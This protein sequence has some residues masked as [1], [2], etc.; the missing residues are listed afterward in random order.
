MSTVTMT[1]PSTPPSLEDHLTRQLCTICQA[2]VLWVPIRGTL[3]LVDLYEWE[4]RSQ[5]ESCRHTRRAHPGRPVSCG[6]CHNTG[7]VGADRPKGRMVAM[8]MAWS[9][10]LHIRIIGPRT[11]RRRG[12][13]LYKFHQ[14][15]QPAAAQHQAAA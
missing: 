2:P 14:C 15:L 7:Y 1:R 10:E 4:P 13:A 9:D 11:D 3:I 5:C 8:D 6:R 12:E